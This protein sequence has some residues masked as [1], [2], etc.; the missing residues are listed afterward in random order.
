M[1]SA[2]EAKIQSLEVMRSNASALYKSCLLSIENRIEHAIRHEQRDACIRTDEYD[3]E[4]LT[5]VVAELHRLGYKTRYINHSDCSRLYL[6]PNA[7]LEIT[8]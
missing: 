2:E 6:N 3:K 5:N 7:F 8:W 1:I 4:T